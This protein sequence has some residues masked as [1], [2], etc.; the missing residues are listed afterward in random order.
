MAMSTSAAA[1]GLAG[2][3]GNHDGFGV[4]DGHAVA[5]IARDGFRLVVT[6]RADT[7]AF[8]LL[9]AANIDHH[10]LSR[11]NAFHH[12]PHSLAIFRLAAYHVDHHF[13]TLLDR[14]P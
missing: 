9:V 2:G 4:G 6:D 11:G 12:V 3:L 8:L 1:A 7:F 10:V 14:G 13:P 5:D